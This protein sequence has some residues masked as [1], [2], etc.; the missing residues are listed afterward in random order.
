MSVSDGD[1]T[2]DVSEEMWIQQEEPL[3]P[4]CDVTCLV[5]AMSPVLLCWNR[6][7]KAFANSLDPDET[8]QN[9]ATLVHFRDMDGEVCYISCCGD[10]ISIDDGYPF[11]LGMYQYHVDNEVII[12]YQ[13]LPINLLSVDP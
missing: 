6:I 11:S 12:P 8:P 13:C 4:Q 1:S 2:G 7:L 3:N 5:S 9:V 10:L